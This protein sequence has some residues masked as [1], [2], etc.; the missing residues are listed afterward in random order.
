MNDYNIRNQNYEDK[1]SN[2]S[3]STMIKRIRIMR[4]V[5][6]VMMK[7]SI[8]MN[9]IMEMKMMMTRRVIMITHL[10]IFFQHV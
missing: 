4:M 3:H 10:E 9:M 7:M 1:D 2:D 6:L 5:I 8:L